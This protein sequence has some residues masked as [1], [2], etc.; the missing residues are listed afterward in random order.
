M[1]MG[2]LSVV[3]AIPHPRNLLLST[4]VGPAGGSWPAQGRYV[5][6]L[7]FFRVFQLEMFVK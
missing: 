1:K 4:D 5:K 2:S 3:F 6:K 7:N